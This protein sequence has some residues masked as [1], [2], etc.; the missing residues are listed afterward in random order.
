MKRILISML[1]LLSLSVSAQRLVITKSVVDC[2]NTEYMRPVT[3][4][5]ELW[6]KSTKKMTIHSVKTDCGCTKVDYPKGSIAGGEHFQV[7]VTYDARQ[8]GH[9]HKMAAIM[10]NASE[11]P[12]FLTMTGVVLAEMEGSFD[13]YPYEIGELR[14]DKRDLEFD[15][16]NKG[17]MPVQEVPGHLQDVL[18]V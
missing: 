12:V 18:E 7:K 15:D 6:N 16:D 11:K 10:S 8:L 4:T 13:A 9:F 17:D 1:T 14:L 3:A 5:F 2:G